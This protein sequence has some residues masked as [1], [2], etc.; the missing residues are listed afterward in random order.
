MS[1]RDFGREFVWRSKCENLVNR[2]MDIEIGWNFSVGC[3]L[4]CIS[5][6]RQILPRQAE[7][8][9][10]LQSEIRHSGSCTNS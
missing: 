3:S 7:S 1:D 9:L 2:L 8:I 10:G 5:L 6:P 4:Y